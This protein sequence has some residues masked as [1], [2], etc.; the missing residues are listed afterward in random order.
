MPRA[1]QNQAAA[2][3]QVAKLKEYLAGGS[4]ELLPLVDQPQH[5]QAS[6]CAQGTN[7]KPIQIS[8][9]S[10]NCRNSGAAIAKTVEQANTAISNCRRLNC[11]DF[12]RIQ[13]VMS[14]IA[15]LRAASRT[16]SLGGDR[17]SAHEVAT[18]EPPQAGAILAASSE[19]TSISHSRRDFSR[20]SSVSGTP[21][22]R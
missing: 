18:A 17:A 5:R 4:L 12:M 16:V 1:R 2:P 11:T 3:E 20:G 22:D 21:T 19:S 6:R 9:G 10:G 7:A 15:P 8:R 14:G 13:F